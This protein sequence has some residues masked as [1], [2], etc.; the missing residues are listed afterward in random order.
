M[1]ITIL[2]ERLRHR[3]EGH[4]SMREEDNL[5]LRVTVSTGVENYGGA[6]LTRTSYPDRRQKS[7]FGKGQRT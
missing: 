1:R 6:S 5:K 7:L 3:I 2:V 4:K